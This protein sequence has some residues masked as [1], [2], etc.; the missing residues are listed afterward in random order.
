[1][2]LTLLFIENFARYA[3]NS[4]FILFIIVST[5]IDVSL[6]PKDLQTEEK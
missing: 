5:L 6:M 1:M 2:F 4:F 3:E